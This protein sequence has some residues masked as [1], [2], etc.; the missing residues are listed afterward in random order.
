MGFTTLRKIYET[1]P[2]TVKRTVCQVPFGWIAGR[3]Y[4]KVYSRGV[5]VDAMNREEIR[6]YQEN[7]LGEMLQFAT[8]QVPAYRPYRSA[9]ERFKPFDAL[10]EFPLIVKDDLQDRFNDYLPRDFSKIPNYEIST[11]GTSGNQLKFYVD[12]CSQAVDTAFVH[13]L[14]SRMGYTPRCRKVTF[15]GV[16]FPNLK[17]GVY[18]QHNPV[19]NELQFS[20]FHMGEKNIPA[21]LE[22]ITRFRPQY[23]HG[24]PS[25]IDLLAGYVLRCGLENTL[26][27]I[28]AVFLVSEGITNVQRDRI[29]R[30]FRTRVFSFYGHSERL[31]IGGECEKNSTYHHF[32]DYG[33]LEIVD[34]KGYACDKE[35]ERGEIVGTGFLNRS[36]PLIRYRTDD[37]AT[38]LDSSCECGRHHE[39]FTDVKGRWRQEMVMGHN[40]A[41]ISIASL[42]M[43]G[44]IFDKV[45][46][47]QYFQEREGCCIIRV[48]VVP[49]FAE[50]DRLAIERAYQGKVGDELDIRVCIVED[51]SLT[52]R[53][54]LKIL[55]TQLKDI[56]S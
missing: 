41:R 14:W 54:K 17:E 35:G 44:S 38:R 18:W 43:H 9:V 42:N 5:L 56:S 32:P 15:R 30:A 47:Y 16:A 37:F 40:G 6:A 19:Y 34:E 46:R 20:P 48:M 36:M 23:F 50:A 24:Y 51:I 10:K 12:D 11:G 49:G 53:G 27:R 45:V 13:R 22:Q 4:R 28:K 33:V 8:D 2:L 55:D 7:S 3:E 25:A 52:A 21:Y 26:P 31:V 29:E 1:L 39:R